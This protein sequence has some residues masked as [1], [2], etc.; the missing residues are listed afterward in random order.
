ML[1]VKCTCPPA[2]SGATG[3][4]P[5]H[6]LCDGASSEILDL[7]RFDQHKMQPQ[8]SAQQRVLW[9]T[10]TLELVLVQLDIQTLLLAQRT[11]RLWHSLITT[12][13][14]IQK[15]LFY[16]P[17]DVKKPI[18]NPILAKAFP[19]FF[20]HP[21]TG[22][23]DA[24]FTFMT[25]DSIQ[26]PDK[27]IAYNRREA[28]WRRMLVRQPPPTNFAFIDVVLGTTQDPP[29]RRKIIQVNLGF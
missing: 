10:D 21:T 24:H 3:H 17:R 6:D 16:L 2:Q 18:Y 29:L 27:I 4:C 11:C 23:T 13:P 12:S 26:N 28:S 8:D 19:A 5:S 7:L 20:P 1:N 14:S 22:M 25:F 15:A 9:T